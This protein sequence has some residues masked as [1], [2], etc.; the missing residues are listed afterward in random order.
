MPE[1][2]TR[3][4]TGQ[5]D[6][7]ASG[8]G[9]DEVLL[10]WPENTFAGFRLLQEYLTYPAKFLSVVIGGLATKVAGDARSATIIVEF[11]RP[12][13]PQFRLGDEQLRLNCVP[14]LNL[15]SHD[16]EPIR[17][18]QTKTEYR[19]APLGGG[20]L[21]I[22]SLDSFVGYK[23]GRSERRVYQPFEMF[24]HDL[25]GDRAD[26]CFVRER[27]RPSIVARGAD[28]YVSF[29]D[30]LG[31]ALGSDAEVVSIKL[32]CSNGNLA[33]RLPVGSVDQPTTD[34]PTGLAVTNV[35]A[36]TAEIPA[37][38]GDNLM[39]R[40]VA[41]LARNYGSMSDVEALR[42]ILS[43]Y[44]FRAAHDLLARRR[45]ALL[46]ESLK[47]IEVETRDAVLRGIPVR[48]RHLTL[49][50]EEA[51]M[52]G[53]AELHLFGA[54]INAFFASY[55]GINSLHQVSVHGLDTKA[56]FTWP[57]RFGSGRVV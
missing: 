1:G 11:D 46:M 13:P 8:F 28:T 3:F 25:P 53:E 55:M 36:V 42:S 14:A 2:G 21:T 9:D 50:V 56:S 23:Q 45:L 31:E 18:D 26:R 19:V 57:P 16:A 40:L 20:G 34:L 30:R 29:V 51:K 24:R 6:V 47:S 54:V 15:F 41:N 43:A 48:L 49:S 39:W 12:F 10:P 17:V 38:I 32:T 37:P 5:A 35:T 33:E 27:L 22:H 7:T 4:A 44:D 52:G